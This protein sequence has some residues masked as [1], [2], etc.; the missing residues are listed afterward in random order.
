MTGHPLDITFDLL[1]TTSDPE[2]VEL[3]IAGLSSSDRAIQLRAAEGLL[4]R[5]NTRGQVELI[6]WLADASIDALAVVQR[7]P[8]LLEPGMRQCLL[9]GGR[10]LQQT[11][12]EL[13][14]LLGAAELIPLLIEVLERP[15]HPCLDEAAETLQQQTGRL[16]DSLRDCG[17]PGTRPPRELE[18]QRIATLDALGRACRD[19]A[20]MS[21]PMEIVESILILGTP[22]DA[23]VRQV[24]GHP[25]LEC[26][27][28]AADLMQHSPHPGVI[29][30]VLDFLSESHPDSQ[31]IDV[32]QT[33]SD[34]VF[35][36]HL[37]HWLPQ[38]LSY[39]QLRNL[40]RVESLV[41]MNTSQLAQLHGPLH[42]S[43]ARLLQLTAIPS[44]VRDRIQQWLLK[45]GS[46]NARLAV[47][48]QMPKLDS[49]AIE[50]IISDGLDSEDEQ[51]QVWAVSQLRNPQLKDGFSLLV[52][53]LDSESPAVRAAARNELR[54][55]T[56]DRMI[57][58]FDRIG[59]AASLGAG[60][61]LLKIHPEC[62]EELEQLLES[63]VRSR[64]L[65]AASAAQAMGL[66]P[67]IVPALMRMLEDNDGMVRRIAVEVLGSLPDGQGIRLVEP[68]LDDDSPRVR[69][70]VEELIRSNAAQGT[71]AS[72]P[73]SR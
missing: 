16:F 26:R 34:P 38:Q 37:L 67:Y 62:I 50:K 33:R 59:P 8:G 44:Y 32:L 45:F 68:L 61:L 18:A 22:R 49:S 47:A 21:Q 69:D 3:L 72:L 27:L 64:R 31:V 35:L 58:M 60:E 51:V 55:F 19:Y 39:N 54:S 28:I 5:R 17:P 63:P 14:R 42:L 20:K 9:F 73:P 15:N 36:S 10:E 2:A 43:V 70:A 24:M 71:V 48:E 23:A 6:R 52:E 11:G 53:R 29:Q 13:V 1:Q 56:L 4:R 7:A 41:W 65:R 66:A 30:L 25:A 57:A 40:K 46:P 12:F